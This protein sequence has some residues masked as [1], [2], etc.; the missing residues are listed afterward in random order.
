MRAKREEKTIEM[1]ANKLQTGADVNFKME[2]TWCP[3]QEAAAV[4]ILTCCN[5]AVDELWS[6]HVVREQQVSRVSTMVLHPKRTS[7]H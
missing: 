3:A 5:C 2:C 6:N 1:I 7:F 4:T